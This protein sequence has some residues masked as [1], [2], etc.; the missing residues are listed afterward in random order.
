MII[1]AAPNLVLKQHTG[2]P[3]YWCTLLTKKQIMNKGQAKIDFPHVIK[4]IEDFAGFCSQGKHFCKFGK[5]V[6]I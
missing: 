6:V 2:V 1:L 3:T 5:R 4:I